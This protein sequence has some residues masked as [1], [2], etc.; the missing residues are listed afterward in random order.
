MAKKWEKIRQK[1]SVR[2][3]LSKAPSLFSCGKRGLPR[4]PCLTGRQTLPFRRSLC[5]ARFA[6][7]AL[8]RSLCVAQ[9]FR[10]VLDTLKDVS[11]RIVTLQSGKLPFNPDSHPS[12][13]IVTLQ[14]GKLPFNPDS[15]PSIRIVTLQ[16]G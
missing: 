11:C 10:A 13:R 12:I 2:D 1:T 9:R 4:L 5:C 14:S 3:F 6:A 16:P 15:H 8:R 7:L